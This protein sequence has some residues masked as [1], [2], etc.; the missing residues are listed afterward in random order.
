MSNFINKPFGRKHMNNE[1][2]RWCG[3]VYSC[4]TEVVLVSK[5]GEDE[6]LFV[7]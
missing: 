7:A 5:L 2:M 6:V 3:V 1:V 4:A